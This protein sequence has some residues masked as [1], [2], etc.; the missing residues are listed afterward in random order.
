[1]VAAAEGIIVLAVPIHVAPVA[2]SFREVWQPNVRVV[3]QFEQEWFD[4]CVRESKSIN[5]YTV[6]SD[7]RFNV[8]TLQRFS[9]KRA[10]E[11]QENT[12][13]HFAILNSALVPIIS[14][15]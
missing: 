11:A 10:A 8:S 6:T 7:L 5:R 14:L 1:V 2:E 9:D 15:E 3:R 12:N 4:A 13:L